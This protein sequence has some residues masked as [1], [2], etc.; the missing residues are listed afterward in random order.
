MIITE[1]RKPRGI[2]LGLTSYDIDCGQLDVLMQVEYI[3]FY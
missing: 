3:Q 1:L 2:D